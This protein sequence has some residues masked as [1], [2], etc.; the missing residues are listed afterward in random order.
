MLGGSTKLTRQ[1]AL[2]TRVIRD[3]TH[4]KLDFLTNRCTFVN[5]GNIIKRRLA[6]TTAHSIDDMASPLTWIRIDNVRLG[7]QRA[8]CLR[9]AVRV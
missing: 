1:A 8:R 2:T 9:F 3:D 7:R 4:D 6:Y 5:L